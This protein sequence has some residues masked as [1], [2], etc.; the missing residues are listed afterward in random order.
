LPIP[1]SIRTCTAEGTAVNLRSLI[2]VFAVA[3]FACGGPI[4]MSGSESGSPAPGTP[5]APAIAIVAPAPAQELEFENED[6]DHHGDDRFDIEVKVER[7]AL[8]DPGRCSG[9]GACGHLVLLIDGNAC[10]APNAQS[11]AL[12]FQGLFGRC[13]KPSGTHQLVVQLVDDRGNVLASSAPITVQVRLRGRKGGD[14]HSG[15]H[16]DGGGHG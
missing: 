12:R 10:G 3:A 15:H 9:T 1:A 7:A 2:A 13:L 14:D 16:Q 6:D 11:S 5:A 8:A 4:D